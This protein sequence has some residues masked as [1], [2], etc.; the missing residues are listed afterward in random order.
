MHEYRLQKSPILVGYPLD[1][2]CMHEKND[3]QIQ[4]GCEHT[5]RISKIPQL[6]I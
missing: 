3:Q 5:C 6:I 2:S 1:L 4:F